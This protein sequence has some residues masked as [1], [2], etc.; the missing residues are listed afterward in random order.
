MTED[1]RNHAKATIDRLLDFVD[2]ANVHFISALHG[3]GVGNLSD[4]VNDAYKS[5]TR[6]LSTSELSKLLEKAVESH[7]PPLIQGRRVKLR[8]AHPGGT[9]PPTVVIHGNQLN[10]LPNL[11][12]RLSR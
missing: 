5:A 3:S 1:D 4:S 8:F 7:N 6:E 2:Y 12:P 9:N 10:K 11:E